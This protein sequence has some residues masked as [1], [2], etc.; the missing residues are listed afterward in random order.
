MKSK[1]D[2]PTHV[3]TC[4]LLRTGAAGDSVLLARRSEDV[5]T[6]SGAWAGVSGYLEPGVTPLEQ[7]YTEL[8]EE[9]S[10]NPADV[11]LLREG[12]QLAIL[13]E[14]AGLSWIVHP[15]LFRLLSLDKVAFDWEAAEHRWVTPETITSLPTVPKLAEAFA[16]VYDKPADIDVPTTW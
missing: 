7:A 14:A 9:V 3:V 4:F 6:Y 11:E 2:A 16:S 1:S 10:L 12:E 5:R 8:R 13:D 15:F